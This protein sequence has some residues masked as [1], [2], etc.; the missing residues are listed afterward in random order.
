ML[1]KFKLSSLF[2]RAINSLKFPFSQSFHHPIPQSYSF[3]PSILH[4][5][6][7]NNIN[8]PIKPNEIPINDQ[9]D[10][11]DPLNNM[12][13]PPPIIPPNNDQN[14]DFQVKLETFVLETKKFELTKE[15]EALPKKTYVF[16]SSGQSALAKNNTNVTFDLG[17]LTESN[18]DYDIAFFMQAGDSANKIY[19]I[20]MILDRSVNKSL[21]REIRKL[22]KP[23]EDVMEQE[24]P[25]EGPKK[26]SINTVLKLKDKAFRVKIAEIQINPEGILA[27]CIPYKDIDAPENDTNPPVITANPS[28]NNNLK[29]PFPLNNEL[30]RIFSLINIIKIYLGYDKIQSFETSSFLLDRKEE[31]SNEKVDELMIKII[32]EIDKIGRYLKDDMHLTSQ[33]FIESRSLILRVLFI[34]RKLEKIWESLEIVNR[35][36]KMVEDNIKKM[37]LINKAR[38]CLDLINYSAD[39]KAKEAENMNLNPQMPQPHWKKYMDQLNLIED[40]SSKERI[41]KEIERFQQ[42]ERNSGEYHK[43]STYLDEVFSI[44][45]GKFTEPYW[46]VKN[47]NRILEENIYGLDKVKIFQYIYYNFFNFY[48]KFHHFLHQILRNFCLI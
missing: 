35:N 41:K 44:P 31:V 40:P 29:S 4:N 27:T 30:N 22:K 8:E 15:E 48:I 21:K 9:N 47:T 36:F 43:I 18:L 45:W 34:R 6:S 14:Q 17:N 12:N 32:S 5:L 46:N 37:E 23:K 38:M 24:K 26:T 13:I 1:R 10:P 42:L 28:Q 39:R 19:R 33:V 7:T 16:F 11:K 2:H 20:G 3:N 25:E